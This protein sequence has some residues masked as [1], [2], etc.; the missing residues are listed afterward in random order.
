MQRKDIS[1]LFQPKSIQFHYCSGDHVVGAQIIVFACIEFK[2]LEAEC[3]IHL[4]RFD[5]RMK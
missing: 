4:G 3:R 1:I 2:L 5:V